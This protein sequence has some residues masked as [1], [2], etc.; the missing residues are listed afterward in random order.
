[1]LEQFVRRHRVLATF[2]LVVFLGLLWLLYL[3]QLIDWSH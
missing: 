3:V 2:V 1:M